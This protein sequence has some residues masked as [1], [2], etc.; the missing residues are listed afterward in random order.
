MAKPPDD[1]F[2]A[3]GWLQRFF[4]NQGKVPVGIDQETSS[5]GGQA[6]EVLWM[7]TFWQERGGDGW[8]KP[9]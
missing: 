5:M 8:P 2:V 7:V 9:R 3:K 6:S 4:V 1:G